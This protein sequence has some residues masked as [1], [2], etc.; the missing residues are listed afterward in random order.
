MTAGRGGGSL[1]GDRG[2]TA[3]GGTEPEATIRGEKVPL[4]TVA[5]L[6]RTGTWLRQGDGGSAVTKGA[7]LERDGSQM[8]GRGRQPHGGRQ[9]RLGGYKCRFWSMSPALPYQAV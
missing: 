2:A 5:Q 3:G 7:K 1:R 4:A 9:Q 6:Q 8:R